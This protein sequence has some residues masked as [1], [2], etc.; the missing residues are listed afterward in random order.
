MKGIHFLLFFFTILIFLV[1]LQNNSDNITN[2]YYQ[3]YDY[4]SDDYSS[5]DSI[6]E[7]TR[8]YVSK[9]TNRVPINIPTRGYPPEYQ[10]MGILTDPNNPENIKP[11][12]GRQTYPGSN[13]YNYFTK[14]DSH[15]SPSIPLSFDDKDCTK[16]NGCKELDNQSQISLNDINYNVQLYEPKTIRYIPY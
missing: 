6:E 10:N 8:H 2:N 3:L 4:S 12:Y 7:P 5:D 13:K 9:Y 15:L 11:L 14:K 16:E 1:G